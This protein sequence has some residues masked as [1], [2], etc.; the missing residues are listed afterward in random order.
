MIT[1][2]L[3]KL[4][5]SKK[6]ENLLKGNYYIIQWTPNIITEEKINIGV[7]FEENLNKQKT[8]RMI[9][10][11]ERIYYMYTKNIKFNL[12]I[13]CEISQ[14]HLLKNELKDGKITE[15]INLLKL[16]F[17]QGISHK[18]IITNLYENLIPLGKKTSE[19]KKKSFITK[20]REIIFK[21]LKND[22]K[23]NLNLLYESHIPENSYLDIDGQIAYLPFKK[24]NGVATLISANYV[25]NQRIK[26][27]LF[28]GYRD[29]E[30]ARNIKE[31]KNN[32]IF[33]AL[34][35]W[36]EKNNKDQLNIENELDKF[37]WLTK[38]H[39]IFVESNSNV[40]NLANNISTWCTDG[41]V[42]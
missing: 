18:E 23:L 1:S 6:P 39:N 5:Y 32:A 28:D 25:D 10:V 15:Q 11:Y 7:I 16:G 4:L 42:A 26:C 41:K 33:I 12:D 22:L 38:K 24:E 37:Y 27:N 17:T 21:E 36:K 9:D 35:Q 40:R 13:A 3:N 30:I 31:N 34:P 20:S 2:Q 19:R 8:V 14:N 29:I